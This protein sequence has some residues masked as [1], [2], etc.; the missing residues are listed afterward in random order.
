MAIKKQLAEQI[1]RKLSGG[2]V[3]PDRQI[4]IREIMLD[5]D[6]LR[7]EYVKLL[8][9]NNIKSGH[10]T[11]D[12]S[13]ISHY[14]GIA[15]TP[16]TGIGY[17]FDLPAKPIDLPR[18]VGIHA[19]YE[20]LPY[21][22]CIIID[23]NQLHSYNRKTALNV[24]GKKYVY[25]R[26]AKGVFS[27]DIWSVSRWSSP[28]YGAIYDL[29]NNLIEPGLIDIGLA[30]KYWT[31]TEVDA[32]HAYLFDKSDGSITS[33]VKSLITQILPVRTFEAPAGRYSIGDKMDGYYIFQI[34]G[35]THYQVYGK[36]AG[37][38]TW[39]NLYSSAVGS[40]GFGIGDSES[41]TDAII[42]QVGHTSST[43][44]IAAALGI[45]LPVPSTLQADIIASSK[46]IL[47][48]E[49]YPLTPD[50]ESAILDRLFEKYVPT[51]QIPHDE[52]VDGQ[53]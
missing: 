20:Y 53:K 17:Q 34:I 2:N 5:M 12:Q 30:T 36:S 49:E 39:S 13:F 52:V 35:T 11:I 29:Y 32:T 3:V 42:A 31:S 6:Q 28:S 45:V 23:V 9:Y 51:K 37:N 4:D 15:V 40:T 18:N 48:S 47:E 14:S 38:S 27:N 25:F 7:D 21:D 1:L 8:Y 26:N 50:A 24:S 43:A 33:S 41:N 44:S 19:I 16:V 46:D 22:Q 10:Y